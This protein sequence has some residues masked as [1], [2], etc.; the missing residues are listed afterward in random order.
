MSALDAL[1]RRIA[2]ILTAG[3]GDVNEAISQERLIQQAKSSTE[4]AAK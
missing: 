2:C 3:P 4:S 1:I